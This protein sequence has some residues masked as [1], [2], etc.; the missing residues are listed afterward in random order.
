MAN[1]IFKLIFTLSPGFIPKISKM[2]LNMGCFRDLH[3]KIQQMMKCFIRVASATVLKVLMSDIFFPKSHDKTL[4]KEKEKLKNP[5]PLRGK[6]GYQD[7]DYGYLIFSAQLTI[8]SDL[9]ENRWFTAFHLPTC[10]TFYFMVYSLRIHLCDYLLFF[11]LTFQDL[12]D[13]FWR[14]WYIDYSKLSMLSIS[15]CFGFFLLILFST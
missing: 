4:L 12:L 6:W 3:H 10:C 15:V 14:M 5:L 9:F 13:I 11:F 2:P 7:L 1:S 8:L